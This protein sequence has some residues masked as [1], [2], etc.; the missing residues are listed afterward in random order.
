MPDQVHLNN[1]LN[2]INQIIEQLEQ[3]LVNLITVLPNPDDNPWENVSIN[4]LK[5]Y[6]T[7]VNFFFRTR[8]EYSGST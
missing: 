5:K 2:I 6:E 1:R 3:L 8:G 4:I 7:K